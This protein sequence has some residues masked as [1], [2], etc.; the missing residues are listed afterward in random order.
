M[1]R[2]ESNQGR[3][4]KGGYQIGGLAR[5]WLSL[6][7]CILGVSS[8]HAQREL[9]SIQVEPAFANFNGGAGT[10]PLRVLFENRGPS[11]RAVLTLS[12]SSFRMSYPVELPSGAAKS[13]IAYVPGGYRYEPLQVD[14]RSTRESRGFEYRAESSNY[15]GQQQMLLIGGRPGQLRFIENLNQGSEGAY[16][17]GT[18][19]T[20]YGKPREL[21]DRACG[22]E[23]FALV[24]LGEGS[25]RMSDEEVRAVQEYVMF[26]GNVLLLGGASGAVQGDSRWWAALPLRPGVP[27]RSLFPKSFK[28]FGTDGFPTGE[29]AAQS[30]VP[31]DGSQETRALG[32][33]VLASKQF[34]FGTVYVCPF[35]LLDAPFTRWEGRAKFLS[36]VLQFGKLER[37]RTAFR[38]IAGFDRVEQ[39]DYYGGSPYSGSM[40]AGST[41]GD[42]NNV[43]T[44]ELPDSG[45]VLT[46]LMVYLAVVVPINFLALRR[47]R[48]G[49]LAWVTA[50]AISLGFAAVFFT[51]AGNLYS[52]QLSTAV[53][54][55]VV[56][57]ENAPTGFAWGRARLFFPRGGRY[58]LGLV[59]VEN[60]SPAQ[61]GY[62]DYYGSAFG[63]R[64]GPSKASTFEAMGAVDVGDIRS[65]AFATSNLSFHEFE[66]QQRVPAGWIQHK[67]APGASG[68]GTLVNSSPYT[69]AN[70]YAW[71]DGKWRHIPELAPGDSIDLETCPDSSPRFEVAGELSKMKRWMVYGLLRGLRLGPQVGKTEEGAEQVYFCAFLGGGSK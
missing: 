37:G 32:I 50:P 10:V 64:G 29:V 65:T 23:S 27:V 46:I 52:A 36:N 15:P 47:M 5:V 62:Y 6:G 38:L 68:A 22:Y 8:A 26:G 44:T 12:D 54:G 20:A 24:V 11:T 30:G 63:G 18:I 17:R 28:K 51:F 35:D 43:F 66:F 56:L 25:E 58:D 4:F 59:D 39:E 7:V 21:P 55:I 69:L 61:D 14:F 1:K 70:A 41:E 60:V 9:V 19:Q 42:Q 49:E 16:G 45:T 53:T 3:G 67:K 40:L 71:M 2:T 13:L 31:T 33:R 48:R 57:D 34:G